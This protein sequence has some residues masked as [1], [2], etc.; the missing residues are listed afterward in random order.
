M[1]RCSLS[2][3]Q[4]RC[5]WQAG[6]PVHLTTTHS[7]IEAVKDDLTHAGWKYHQK[8]KTAL[9]GM[10]LWNACHAF[11]MCVFRKAEFCTLNKRTP[12]PLLEC[13]RQSLHCKEPPTLSYS[14]AFK[15]GML[16]NTAFPC[17]T[18]WVWGSFRWPHILMTRLGKARLG[19]CCCNCQCCDMTLYQIRGYGKKWNNC[20]GVCAL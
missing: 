6:W 12:F 1:P 17:F 8:T 2:W 5:H 19:V 14:S 20:V 9:Q 3:F 15:V 10:T 11:W 7:N 16:H 4:R 18:S 13:D